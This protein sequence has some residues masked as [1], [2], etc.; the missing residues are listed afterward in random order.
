MNKIFFDISIFFSPRTC[1][2]D[3]LHC[4]YECVCM[5]EAYWLK[6]LIP[7][8]IVIWILFHWSIW[9]EMILLMMMICHH[10]H[11]FFRKIKNILKIKLNETNVENSENYTRKQ[12]TLQFFSLSSYGSIKSTW[13]KKDPAKMKH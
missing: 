10:H 4:V 5:P 9:Y 13:I 1:N 12:A 3:E 7:F 11:Q 2:N 8:R 6:D